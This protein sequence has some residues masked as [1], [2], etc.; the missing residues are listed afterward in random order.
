[1]SKL[2][3]YTKRNEAVEAI[4]DGDTSEGLALILCAWYDLALEICSALDLPLS[5]RPPESQRRDDESG[6]RVTAFPL[7]QKDRPE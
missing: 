2:R 6:A 7:A 3:S 1:M 5:S 4:R